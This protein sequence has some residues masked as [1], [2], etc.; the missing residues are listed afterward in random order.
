M[1]IYHQAASAGRY[2]QLI[3]TL[4][5][6]ASPQTAKYQ[7]HAVR[8]DYTCGVVVRTADGF[9]TITLPVLALE[10]MADGIVTDKDRDSIRHQLE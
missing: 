4:L 1:N 10:L 2:P 7:G 8:P 6:T 3:Q 9:K 5:N